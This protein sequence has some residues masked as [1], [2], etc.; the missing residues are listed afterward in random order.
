MTLWSKSVE[1][2]NEPWSPLVKP[3]NSRKVAPDSL[4]EFIVQPASGF[5]E[6]VDTSTEDSGFTHTPQTSVAQN[7]YLV[8]HEKQSQYEIY[9]CLTAIPLVAWKV[10]RIVIMQY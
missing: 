6:M 3:L 2:L 9:A 5:A 10:K 4:E 7:R 8:I 1:D